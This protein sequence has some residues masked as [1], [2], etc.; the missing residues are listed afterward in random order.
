MLIIA[1]EYTLPTI[2]KYLTKK[3]NVRISGKYRI[4]ADRALVLCPHIETLVFEEGVEDIEDAVLIG[5]PSVKRVEFPK[6]L[7]WIGRGSFMNCTELNEVVFNNPQT[8]IAYDVFE[9]SKWFDGFTDD[10]IIV[11]GQLLKYKGSAENVVIPE[12]VVRIAFRAFEDNENIKTGI[13]PSTLKL[14]DVCAFSGCTNLRNITL[15]DDLECIAHLVFE[16][17]VKLKEILL[18]RRHMTY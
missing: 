13:C 12:G 14:I 11:H 2:R 10:F 15:N 3:S 6:S 5:N 7:K 18:P 9:G 17:C 8:R 4:I 16:G 1:S